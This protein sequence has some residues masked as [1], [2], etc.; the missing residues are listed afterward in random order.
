MADFIR[1]IVVVG[2]PAQGSLNAAE[3]EG[4]IFIGAADGLRINDNGPVRPLAGGP[5]RGVGIGRTGLFG[6]GVVVYH[7][8][9]ISGGYQEGEFGA[10]KGFDG[11]RVFPVRLGDNADPVA[12]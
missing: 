3:D 9:D 4:D 11:G 2:E 1:P 12:L 8:V 7:G 5:R 6:R 10:A